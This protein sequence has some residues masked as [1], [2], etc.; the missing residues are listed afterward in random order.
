ML[1]RER[2]VLAWSA[3]FRVSSSM[4]CWTS[5]FEAGSMFWICESTFESPSESIVYERKDRTGKE[6]LSKDCAKLQFFSE[7]QILMG[8]LVF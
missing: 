1:V 6:R 8:H 2:A 3:A 7:L 5:S 4:T